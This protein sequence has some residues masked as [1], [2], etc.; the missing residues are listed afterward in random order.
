MLAATHSSRSPWVVIKYND[1][2]RG[3]LNMLR[4][5][6]GQLDYPDKDFTALQEPDPEILGFGLPFLEPEGS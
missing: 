2:R 3:R 6:L 5:F 4:H 1:K